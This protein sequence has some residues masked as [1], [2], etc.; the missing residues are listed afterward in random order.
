MIFVGV[1]GD[2]EG[3]GR[4]ELRLPCLA[5]PWLTLNLG[6]TSPCLILADLALPDPALPDPAALPYLKSS[7][8]PRSTD[9][10]NQIYPSYQLS[11]A[12]WRGPRPGGGVLCPP[13]WVLFIRPSCLV[14]D[15]LAKNTSE[16]GISHPSSGSPSSPQAS[17][18]SRPTRRH[19]DGLKWCG[20]LFFFFLFSVL[21]S[22]R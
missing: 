21:W 12:L 14:C 16:I 1:G 8:I 10:G 20:D 4:C 19:L 15:L 13:V 11:P 7:Q 3:G 5:L 17:T 2:G 18:A 6:L 22:W 9:P